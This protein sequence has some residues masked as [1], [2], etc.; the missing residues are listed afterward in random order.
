MDHDLQAMNDLLWN[1]EDPYSDYEPSRAGGI[2][3]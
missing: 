1:R 3:G 2:R